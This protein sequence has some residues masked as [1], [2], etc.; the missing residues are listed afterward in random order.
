[1]ARRRRK[2]ARRS[3][4]ERPRRAPVRTVAYE[5]HPPIRLQRIEVWRKGG[6]YA[7]PHAKGAIR[8]VFTAQ[9]GP[10]G[11]VLDVLEVTEK[12]HVIRT[13]LPGAV[14]ANQGL[15]SRA[16]GE[17]NALTASLGAKRAQIRISYTTPE[18]RRQSF[19]LD[20]RTIDQKG[21]ALPRVE[22]NNLMV[23]SIVQG[24]RQRGYRTQYPIKLVDWSKVKTIRRKTEAG[25]VLNVAGRTQV[26]RR[27]EVTGVSIQ[28]EYE[29]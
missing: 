18:G 2:P 4:M 22:I 19:R 26:A 27:Q 23:G 25:G 29:K 5:G 14:E 6:R 12:T 15:I 3:K 10:T 21:L 24:L 20:H 1:M 11:T 16:L 7:K 13:V 28:V 8:R 17:T 9:V